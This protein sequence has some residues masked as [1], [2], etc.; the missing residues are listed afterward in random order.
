MKRHRGHSL[1]LNRQHGEY[2]ECNF[3][4]RGGE[5]PKLCSHWLHFIH[6]TRPR[7]LNQCTTSLPF[8]AGANHLAPSNHPSPPDTLLC[9][10]RPSLPRCSVTPLHEMFLPANLSRL[11]AL[12][13]FCL[14]HERARTQ[15]RPCL[16][17][18]GVRLCVCL[19]VG[20]VRGFK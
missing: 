6:G 5:E 18:R 14:S 4:H 15:Q 20:I 12:F 11:I 7:S 2:V 19:C 8:T 17:K 3:A 13:S 9:F 16:A 10:L 1:Y